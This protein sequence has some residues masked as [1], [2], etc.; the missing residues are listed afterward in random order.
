MEVKID[1]LLSDVEADRIVIVTI[2]PVSLERI[3]KITLEKIDSANSNPAKYR[4]PFS[5]GILVA[6]LITCLIA[7][8]MATVMP[9]ALGTVSVR[10][11]VSDDGQILPLEKP[12]WGITFSVGHVRP[13]G[14]ELTCVHTDGAYVGQL[15]IEDVYYLERKSAAGWDAVPPIVSKAVWPWN[16][17]ILSK[18]ESYTWTLDWRDMYGE[19]SPGTYR[20]HQCISEVKDRHI[21]RT[22][23][24]WIEFVIEGET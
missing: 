16:G 10:Y 4:R 9:A 18:Y 12:D 14:M 24:Y 19:L 22:V 11:P 8:V 5:T 23:I 20:L 13:T 6:I 2:H 3:K 7:A 15:A 17:T 21:S 1:E